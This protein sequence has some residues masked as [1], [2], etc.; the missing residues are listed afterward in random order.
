MPTATPMTASTPAAETLKVAKAPFDLVVLVGEEPLPVF[1]TVFEPEMV[2]LVE[3]ARPPLGVL[4]AGG[5]C[6][7]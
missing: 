7:P 3:E 5:Y 6:E 2:P 4:D 1:A